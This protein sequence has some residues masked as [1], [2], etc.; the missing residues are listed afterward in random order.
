MLWTA[1]MALM[2][3]TVVHCGITLAIAD[4]IVGGTA[5]YLGEFPW[6]VSLKLQGTHDC[7]ATVIS[8]TWLVSAAHWNGPPNIYNPQILQTSLAG[9]TLITG[10]QSTAMVLNIKSIII[11]P[12]YNSF[13][14][15]YD[16]SLVELES[17]LTFNSYI[18]PICLPVPS[19]NFPPGMQCTVTGWGQLYEFNSEL[20]PVQLPKTSVG[21]LL[22]TCLKFL[23][24]LPA[25]SQMMCAG[26]LAGK[27]DACQGD[28]GGPLVCQ[29]STGRYFLAGIV[30]WGIGCAEVNRPGV[31]TRV[32]SIQSWIMS[33][34]NQ[35][36]GH[37]DWINS[38]STH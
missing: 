33:Y 6:Q 30:S 8:K 11:H 18:Q 19:Y 7:G 34:I 3:P 38:G 15:D 32:T 36:N 25:N 35:P 24:V 17:P 14:A 9:A 21:P 28:S 2:K 22:S 26:F 23:Y 1:M 20:M 13:T 16:V 27:V 5:A 10:A 12:N 37:S 29:E 31:Y 4:R